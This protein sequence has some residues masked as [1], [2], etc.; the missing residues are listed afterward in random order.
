MDAGHT[1][2]ELEEALRHTA[3]LRRLALSL[4]KDPQSADELVQETWIRA[5]RAAPDEGAS[6]AWLGTVLRRLVSNQGR[7]DRRREARERLRAR[8]EALPS[9][10]DLVQRAELQKRLTEAVLALPGAEREAILLHYFEDCT[11]AEIARRQG[12]PASTVRARVRRG[13]AALRETLDRDYGTRD[14]WGALFLV[15]FGGAEWTAT[16]TAISATSFATTSLLGWLVIAALACTLT[17]TW[18]TRERATLPPLENH[19]AGRVEA[20]T[21]STKPAGLRPTPVGAGGREV[22]DPWQAATTGEARTLSSD[23]V[24]PVSPFPPAVLHAQL[25]DGAGRPLRDGWLRVVDS[26]QRASSS[27]NGRVTLELPRADDAAEIVV[28]QVGSDAFAS[29]AF[30]VRVASGSTVDLGEQRL[31]PAAIVRG[32]V[33]NDAGEPIGGVTVK[34]FGAE[35]GI[36]GI[37]TDDRRLVGPAHHLPVPQTTTNADGN[38]ELRAVP[39]GRIRLWSGGSAH[40]WQASERLDLTAGSELDG[41]QLV[42]EP[43]TARDRIEGIVLGPDDQPI[44]HAR[45]SARMRLATV[46]VGQVF[47]TDADGRFA[48]D[49]RQ[50]IPHDFEA[51]DSKQRWPRVAARQVVPGT[52][53]LVLRFR[54]THRMRVQ[55]R[56]ENGEV[57]H[58]YDWQLEPARAVLPEVEWHAAHV[59]ADGFARIA[60]LDEVFFLGIRA[61]DRDA[62]R[63]GPF[64]PGIGTDRIEIVLT[65]LPT[66]SGR[67]THADSAIERAEVFM[68]R[69]LEPDHRIMVDG[70][71]SLI[72]PQPDSVATTDAH[73][74]FKLQFRGPGRY[75][76]R[77]KLEGNVIAERWPL[78]L[79]SASVHGVT[80]KQGDGAELEVHYAPAPGQ[81][82]AGRVV[83]LNHGAGEP[84]SARF[85]ED[86]VLVFDGLTAGHWQLSLAAEELPLRPTAVREFRASGPSPIHWTCELF[87]GNRTRVVL[88]DRD[89]ARLA[90]TGNVK[91]NGEP[92][93]GWI[94]R[95]RHVGVQH[96]AEWFDCGVDD[97]GNFALAF[98]SEGRVSVCASAP[99]EWGNLVVREDLELD[100]EGPKTWQLDF[101]TG[102]LTARGLPRL[103]EAAGM[104]LRQ[105]MTVA[106]RELYAVS[107]VRP[108]ANGVLRVPRLPV[109]IWTIVHHDPFMPLTGRSTGWEPIGEFVIE[110]DRETRFTR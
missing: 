55:L 5:W 65:E 82:A 84:Q 47:E 62:M 93:T 6:R 53:D 83:V 12:L 66:V 79:G 11:S 106:G 14:C 10:T 36:V 108:D 61:S 39:C 86:G 18:M 8:E 70:Q 37:M 9:A 46:G 25:F 31:G 59:E 26:A 17:V 85:G 98:E 15:H 72:R 73:G 78:E 104:Q 22:V 105:R 90:V 99:D 54:A 30:E 60:Q 77:A 52:D 88:R 87:D 91:V 103:G 28:V 64:E 43:I 34:A 107:A 2:L 69:L 16:T 95:G 71:R 50:R 100:G 67:V 32:R 97:E 56:R 3:W 27:T 58:E 110:A 7:G 20:P 42:L 63:Y 29:A 24:A 89:P 74:R 44:P 38:F 41:V 109:G 94:V 35:V 51:F 13:L 40:V 101:E 57:L 48:F 1:P 4:V 80:L 96:D 23:T 92:V 45:I 49:L 75:V 102:S 68:H 33:L 21:G 76:L 19:L 81:S